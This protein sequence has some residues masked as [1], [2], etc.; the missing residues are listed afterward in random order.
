MDQN[1]PAVVKKFVD[2]QK[3]PYQ[4]VMGDQDVWKAFGGGEAIPM[5][6]IIDRNGQIR[7]RKTG[8]VPTAEYEKTVVSFLK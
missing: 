2:Q 3:V 8:A 7:D 6:V 4:I 1:G 5:T